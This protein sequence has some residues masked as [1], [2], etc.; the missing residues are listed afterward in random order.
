[1]TP[2]SPNKQSTHSTTEAREQ[3]ISRFSAYLR[4]A[5]DERSVWAKEQGITCYRLYDAELASY[6]LA[7]DIYEG[8][9]AFS[10]QRYLVVGQYRSADDADRAIEQQRF[11]EAVT[12]ASREL[13]VAKE[14]IFEKARHFDRSGSHY[15][16]GKRSSHIVQV[17]ESGHIFELD[18]EGHLD[19]GIFLDH[20]PTRELIGQMSKG[21]HF[22]N[23]FAYTGTASV[24]AAA[25]GALSTTT[26]DLSQ[27]YVNWAKRNMELNG[28]GGDAH[29]FIKSDAIHWLDRDIRKGASYDLVFVDPPT[30][31][32]SKH[33]GKKTWS[34]ARDH[35]EL[36]QKVAAVLSKQGKAIFSCNMR[37]FKPD[38]HALNRSGIHL[39]D[40][41]RA[42]I[43]K[44]FA[45]NPKI[46]QCYVLTKSK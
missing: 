4:A 15:K 34:V 36:L 14:C 12:I 40:I 22:L 38:E 5:A 39:E 18:L 8:A 26:V 33:K 45:S 3:D 21:M 28:L 20:R 43:P 44:D 23:L 30:F 35:V 2:G 7:I 16:D 29:R 13:G 32:R 24:Y 27:T 37:D 9:A 25:E 42:S 10:G 17:Q 6:A 19:T 46:H 1:M 31:S 41:T 11:S